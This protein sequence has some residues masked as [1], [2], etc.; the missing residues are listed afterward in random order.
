MEGL[1]VVFEDIDVNGVPFLKLVQL[2]GV[3]IS[4][5]QKVYVNKASDFIFHSEVF[6]IHLGNLQI[7]GIGVLNIHLVY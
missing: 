5:G 1:R 6:S 2:N 7:N 3:G 4:Q